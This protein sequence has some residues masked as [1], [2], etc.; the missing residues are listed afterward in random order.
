MDPGSGRS[1]AAGGI[2]AGWLTFAEAV[3][4]AAPAAAGADSMV[5]R[6]CAAVLDRAE[7]DA[8]AAIASHIVMGIAALVTLLTACPALADPDVRTAE[9]DA[10]VAEVAAKVAAP[11]GG[12]VFITALTTGIIMDPIMAAVLA[13]LQVTDATAEPDAVAAVHL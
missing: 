8:A 6:V 9:V 11:V 4:T 5:A 10:A 1:N 2:V 13:E 7:A 12:T 3:A